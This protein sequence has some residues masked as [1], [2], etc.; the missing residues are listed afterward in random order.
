MWNCWQGYL[1]ERSKNVDSIYTVDWGI[2]FQLTAL[3]GWDVGRKV[4]D[5][6]GAFV[7]LGS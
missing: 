3:C 2:G 1:N 7:W 4:K 5:S 6:W